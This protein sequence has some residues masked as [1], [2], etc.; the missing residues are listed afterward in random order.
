[1]EILSVSEMGIEAAATKASLVLADGGL[2]VYPTDTLYGLGALMQSADAITKLHALKARDERKFLSFIVP[3]AASIETYTHMNDAARSLASRFLPGPL[4][5]TLKAK[6]SVP[7][8]VAHDGAVRIRIPN[9]PVALALARA[10]N[11]PFSATSANISGEPTPATVAGIVA[12]F[13]DRIEDIDLIIDDGPRAGGLASTIISCVG[14]E[15]EIIR[16]GALS[17]EVLGLG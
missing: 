16:E 17:K 7:E 1:M 5:L 2:V 8:L 4:T 3:D 9:D 12:Q 11:E 14:D 10:L 13:G 15:I 6:E